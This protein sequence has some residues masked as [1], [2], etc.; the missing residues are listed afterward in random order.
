MKK[1]KRAS[2]TLSSTTKP[3]DKSAP[4]E[5]APSNEKAIEHLNNARRL[6]LLCAASAE[7]TY[8]D[9]GTEIRITLGI[10]VDY[11]LSLAIDEVAKLGGAT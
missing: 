10:D 1:P 2:H 11:E 9:A 3:A 5:S 6:V 8:H 7:S 4:V